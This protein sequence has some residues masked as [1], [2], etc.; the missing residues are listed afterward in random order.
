MKDREDLIFCSQTLAK[1]NSLLETKTDFWNFWNWCYLL[2]ERPNKIRKKKNI[3]CTWIDFKHVTSLNFIPG[4]VEKNLRN[5]SGFLITGRRDDDENRSS[6]F[7]LGDSFRCAEITLTPKGS[8]PEQKYSINYP[9]FVTLLFV[10][11]LK[12]TSN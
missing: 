3:S 5:R 9:P 12:A 11:Q 1:K 4:L 8:I 6:R 10:S 7:C 2:T